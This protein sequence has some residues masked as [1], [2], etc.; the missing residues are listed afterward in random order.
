[1]VKESIKHWK[2]KPKRFGENTPQLQLIST[3]LLFL[4]GSDPKRLLGFVRG[5][6]GRDIGSI[7][8]SAPAAGEALPCPGTGTTLGRTPRSRDLSEH[9]CKHPVSPEEPLQPFCL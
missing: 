4:F 2:N 6:K 7:P 3:S 9:G 1:M 8:R 5:D